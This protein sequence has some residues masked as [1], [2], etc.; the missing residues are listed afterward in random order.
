M[1][2]PPS[3]PKNVISDLTTKS[4]FIEAVLEDYGYD[5]MHIIQAYHHQHTSGGS[6]S[7]SSYLTPPPVP[8]SRMQ[9]ARAKTVIHPMTGCLSQ[10]ST[11][12]WPTQ[13]LGSLTI[14]CVWADNN[15]LVAKAHG[16]E[17][18]AANLS[19]DAK[20]AAATIKYDISDLY[21][22]LDTISLPEYDNMLRQRLSQEESLSIAIKSYYTFTKD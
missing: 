1:Q 18:G 2:H 14:E 21:M 13:A 19:A 7:S 9:E 22:T 4:G 11:R 12:F 16:V 5:P 17:V 20:A 6:S 3:H 8:S 15:V 10:N